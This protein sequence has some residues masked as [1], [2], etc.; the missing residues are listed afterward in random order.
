MRKG[1]RC[2]CFAF[3]SLATISSFYILLYIFKPYSSFHH[4]VE[5]SAFYGMEHRE[6][7]GMPLSFF[8]KDS[9]EIKREDW[10]KFAP[11]FAKAIIQYKSIPDDKKFFTQSASI[12][13]TKSDYEFGDKFVAT[14]TSR[15]GEGRAKK[16]GGDYYRARL[17]RGNTDYPDGIPCRVFDN[18]N[19]TYAVKAPLVLEGD[20]ILEVRLVQSIE[21]TMETVRQTEAMTV[22]STDFNAIFENRESGRCNVNLTDSIG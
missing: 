3:V 21:G 8:K 12:H 10:K 22:W 5:R 11:K 7:Y 2:P 13:V 18:E 4:T 14:I 16:F 1:V 20:L 19:G 17:I 9:I 15:D 6:T